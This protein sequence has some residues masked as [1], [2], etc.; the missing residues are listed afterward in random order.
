MYDFHANCKSHSSELQSN[1]HCKIEGSNALIAKFLTSWSMQ[2]KVSYNLSNFCTYSS[3]AWGQIWV[4]PNWAWLQMIS[5][6][7]LYSSWGHSFNCQNSTLS[8][9]SVVSYE[10]VHQM[11]MLSSTFAVVFRSISE[12]SKGELKKTMDAVNVT[13]QHNQN[14]KLKIKLHIP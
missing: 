14:H 5:T 8:K 3:T 1:Q 13:R 10:L 12:K 6:L 9:L 7:V 4:S 2:H 11:K